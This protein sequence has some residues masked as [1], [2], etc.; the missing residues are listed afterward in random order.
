M[1]KYFILFSFVISSAFATEDEIPVGVWFARDRGLIEAPKHIV[2]I[3]KGGVHG[4]VTASANRHKVPAR[5][6]HAVVKT[7]SNY[8]CRARSHAGA[9]GIMQTLPA[10]ARGVGVHGKLTDCAIG[11]EAGMRYL[12]QI[13]RQHGTGCAALGLYERGAYARPVCTSYGRKVVRLA[14]N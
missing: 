13:V 1:I 6:A 12:S 3:S 9:I 10:T 11:L 2:G 4:M 5:I 8:N 14:S 7:E